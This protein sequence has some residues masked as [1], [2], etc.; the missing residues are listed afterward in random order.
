VSDAPTLAAGQPTAGTAVPES[1]VI[2]A[3]P[4][5]IEAP[6]KFVNAN[7]CDDAG[8]VAPTATAVLHNV[9]E[10][11]APVVKAAPAGSTLYLE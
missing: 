10:A 5:G 1:Q 8:Q 2:P 9:M 3:T 11:F 7:E 4:E 6:L